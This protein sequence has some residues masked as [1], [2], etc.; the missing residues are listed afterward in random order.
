MAKAR[1]QEMCPE[2]SLLGWERAGSRD[3]SNRHGEVGQDPLWGLDTF[4]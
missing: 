2:L 4:V 1:D 3:G